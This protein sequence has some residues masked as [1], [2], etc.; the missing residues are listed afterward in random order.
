V[1]DRSARY[2]GLVTRLAALVVDGLLLAVVVPAVALGPPAIW[3]ALVGSAPGWLSATAQVCGALVP[4]VYFAGAWW[5][6]GQTLG[7]VVFGVVVRHHRGRHLGVTRSFL[8]AL[9][10]LLLPVIWLLGL[11]LILTDGK[12]RALHD[13]LFGTVVIRKCDVLVEVA[14]EPV[15]AAAVTS[16]R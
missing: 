5:S 7:D 4:L 15:G 3:S 13:R 14:P 8:R 12:R 1:T 6:T 11:V 2:A 10:G 16:P 9:V